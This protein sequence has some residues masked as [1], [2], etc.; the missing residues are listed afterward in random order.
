MRLTVCPRSEVS[1]YLTA[2]VTHF[3]SLIDPDEVHSTLY[4]PLSSTH[5]LQ[6][7]FHDLDDIEMT[8]PKFARY[9]A[10]MEE[11]VRVLVDFGRTLLP[12]D[13]WGLLAHCEAG[14]SRCSAAAITLLVAAGYPPAIAFGLVRRA[15][16]Q[17]MPNRRI[18]RFADEFL[19]TDGKLLTMAETYRR[20]AFLRAGYEDPTSVLAAQNA[21][22]LTPHQRMLRKMQGRWRS[23]LGMQGG[24]FCWEGCESA[25]T[26]QSGNS[27]G[28]QSQNDSNVRVKV[29][30]LHRMVYVMDD[31]DPL[32]VTGTL[33]GDPSKP[34]PLGTF[35]V[36]ER[37]EH[38]Q[39]SAFGFWTRGDSIISGVSSECPGTGY[40]YVGFPLDYWVGFYPAY[41]FHVGSVAEDTLP[42]GCLRLSETAARALFAH[43]R[44]G[45]TVS[46][47]QTQPEDSTLRVR[48]SYLTHSDDPASLTEASPVFM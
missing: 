44:F 16:P 34:P 26:L 2:P 15:C 18:L 41:G 3:V 43:V 1:N 48:H 29:S 24:D 23:L 17:M 7:I 12:L 47:A 8:L 36:G 25:P 31:D 14:I 20:K 19:G 37:I 32:L 33:V 35:R 45:T 6:L 40:R 42:Y 22:A 13:D 5:R 30:L 39:S 28:Q 11:D 27:V 10:P 46:V 38:M 4:P 21:R 9:S